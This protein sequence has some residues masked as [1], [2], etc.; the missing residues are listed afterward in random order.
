MDN[1]EYEFGFII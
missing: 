1:A